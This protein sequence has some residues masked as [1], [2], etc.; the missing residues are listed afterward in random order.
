MKI[1]NDDLIHKMVEETFAGFS[2]E[3]SSAQLTHD[4]ARKCF[5]FWRN[6]KKFEIP[7]NFRPFSFIKNK[8]DPAIKI[9]QGD[10]NYNL[11]CVI[12]GCHPEV[13]NLS[14]NENGIFINFLQ[15]DERKA[16]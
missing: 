12:M 5:I 4:R 14:A 10:E 7:E 8:S 6:N 2:T 9:R 16:A 11:L 13:F 3:D 1:R 15:G